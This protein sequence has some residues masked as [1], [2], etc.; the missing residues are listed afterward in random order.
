MEIFQTILRITLIFLI[1][2][3][4]RK[5]PG[6]AL[7]WVALVFFF[8][9]IGGLLYIIFGSTVTIKLTYQNRSRKV[10]EA[11]RQQLENQMELLK[12]GTVS[13][14]LVD[15]EDS[16]I[17][18][19]NT[20]YGESVL[21][22]RND[23]D[24]ITSGE[25][26]YRKMFADIAQAKD[27]IHV[28]YYAIHNDSIGKELIAL[29]AKKAREGVNVR[30]LVDGLGSITA[31]PL[32]F[33]PLTKAG[34]RVKRIK[35]LLTHFR[36][37]RKI[38]VI[39]GQV[40]YTGGMNIGCKYAGANPK[41]SPWRDTQVR[42]YGEA[43]YVLQYYFLY[44]WMY[45]NGE[46]NRIYAEGGGSPLF[47]PMEPNEELPCQIVGSG[48]DTDKQVLKL[49]YL[50]MLSLAQES[51]ILQT[52]YFIPSMSLLESLKVALSSGV[53]V[54]LMIPERSASFFLGPVTRYFVAQL[55][56][57]GL[58]VLQYDGYIHSKTLRVDTSITCIGSVN[59]D[60]RSLEVDDEICAIF[61]GEEFATRYDTIVAEDISH[62]TEMDYEAFMQRG[63]FKKFTERFF[64]LFSP[65]M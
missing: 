14:P 62:C 4:E 39:D 20:H 3:I 61:Y 30:V 34:G 22:E 11:Y 8:P 50:R 55:I 32:F 63:L 1:V 10:Y 16:L 49:S 28:A 33:R 41:K 13:H 2:F 31:T 17:M 52:P 6:E 46:S 29:L 5:K 58:R 26:K 45:A 23:V 59:I 48:V 51:I 35:P 12:E 7:I 9:I 60:I 40:G 47:P 44:D 43:V 65:L 42:I 21:T 57:L 56:P 53:D 18:H 37:H 54:V 25:E 19:F 15:K 27:H 24:I 38:V 36:Y 64:L